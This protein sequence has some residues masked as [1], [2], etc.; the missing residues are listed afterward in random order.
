MK[1]L[2]RTGIAAATL[3]VAF[4]VANAADVKPEDLA[5]RH[6]APFTVGVSNGYLGNTWRAQFVEDLQAVADDLKA[7]GDFKRVDIVNSTSGAAG[8]IAQVNSLINSGVSALVINPVSGE[9][10]KPVITRAINAGILV[11]IADDPLEHPGVVNVVLD[12]GQWA[13]VPAQWMAETL[14]GKGNIVA[15]DGLA[16]NTANDWRIRARTE[17]LKQHPDIKELSATPAGW[18]PAKARE[19]MTSQLSAHPDI[20]GVLIQDV[21]PEGVVRAYEAAGKP[22]PP[23]SGDY[24]H[25]FLKIWKEKKINAITLA[26]PPGIGA[27]A[28]RVAA[29][30]LRGH[31][32]KPGA[33]GPNPFDPELSNTIII[34]E[35]IAI[36]LEGD[37]TKPWCT[38]LTE[39]ITVDEALERLKGKPD[40]AS[41]D[42]FM[43]D[44][45]TLE[46]YFQ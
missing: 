32:L 19:V 8:Q 3:A 15:I 22:L 13:R 36:S 9:A 40:S 17:V 21:M 35:P 4:T 45:Q 31:K 23:M 41:L 44:A 5:A 12:Q 10:L 33:L 18:D 25:S 30:L 27:D 42:S 37:K 7:A 2:A 11:V 28:L 34:P 1:N 24:L 39:C 6:K 43:T 38:E 26:N 20:D 14:K 16:G 46:R 29:A